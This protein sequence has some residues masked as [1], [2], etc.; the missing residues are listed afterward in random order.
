MPAN[1]KESSQVKGTSRRTRRRRIIY[2]HLYL[3]LSAQ[4]IFFFF[5]DGRHMAQLVE[6]LSC[7]QPWV[8]FP[9]LR[10]CIWWGHT[11]VILAF[12]WWQQEGHKFKVVIGH[13]ANMWLT[14]NMRECLRKKKPWSLLVSLICVFSC[15]PSQGQYVTLANHMPL[16]LDWAHFIVPLN[17]VSCMTHRGEIP[18]VLPLNV[19]SQHF[20][21]LLDKARHSNTQFFDNPWVY[22]RA[23]EKTAWVPFSSP[24]R[25][26]WQPEQ[27]WN[28]GAHQSSKGKTTARNVDG[29]CFLSRLNTIY[30]M[31]RSWNPFSTGA[32]KK[33]TSNIPLSWF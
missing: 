28:L 29:I 19:K 6:C 12:G 23:C 4:V 14:Y 20:Y 21:F 8:Q 13:I 32:I 24:I 10:N 3:F 25:M 16:G 33:W 7:T 22:T 17:E 31:N 26:G 18:A 9:T 30:S 1:G 2:I 5:L 11:D 15:A 27:W